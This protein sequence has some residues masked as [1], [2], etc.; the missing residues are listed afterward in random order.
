MSNSR[1][2]GKAVQQYKRVQKVRCPKRAPQRIK[3]TNQ[4]TKAVDEEGILIGIL[5]GIL[6]GI[7]A[8]QVK[9]WKYLKFL[10]DESNVVFQ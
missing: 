2:P 9:R 5:I 1:W 3:I 4:C 8:I 6:Y 7:N 10:D